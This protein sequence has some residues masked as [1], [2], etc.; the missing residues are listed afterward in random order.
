MRPFALICALI[1]LLFSLPVQADPA[2]DNFAR[3]VE[4]TE[5]LR[6]VRALQNSYANYAQFGLWTEVG[7]LFAAEG[8]FLFD[9]Q[10]KDGQTAKGP[11]AVATFLRTRYGGGRDGQV[12][13]GLSAMMIDSPVINLAADGESAKARWQAI[14]FHGHDGKARIEGGVFVNDYM[15][16]G[17][18]WKIAT[19]H[20]YPQYDGAYEDGWVNW[21]GGDLPVPP[22]HFDQDNAGIAIPPPTGVAAP[23]KAPLAALQARTDRLNEEDRIRNLQSM[24]GFY[25]DRKMWDDVADLFAEDAAVEVGGQGVWRGKAGVRRWLAGIGAAELSHGQL[26]D[27]VQFNV[28]VTIAPGGNE[29]FA[30]GLELGMLGEADQE[31]GWWEIA[32]F[33]NRFVRENGVWKIR[34]MRRFPQMKTDIFLGWGESRITDPV[35]GGANAPD[36]PVPQGDVTGPRTAVPAF[37]GVHPVTGKAVVPRGSSKTV[38]ALPLTGAIAARKAAPV[39]LDEAKRRLARSAAYDG[40]VNVSSAYGFLL[41]DGNPAGFGGLIA[42]KGFKV[43]PFAG[44]YIGRDRVL[45]ARTSGKVPEKRPGISYH[46]LVQPVFLISDDGRSVTGHVRLFQPRTGKTVGEAGAFFGASFWGG[47]YYNEYVLEKG[48]WRLWNLSLDE[49]F[50]K[51]VAWKDGLWAK[52]KDPPPPD[53]NVPARV[54]SG[55][56]FPP[57]IPLKS[58]GKRAE[59]YWGGTGDTWDWPMI[60]PMWFEYTNPVSGRVPPLYHPD[61]IPCAVR[62]ELRLDRN[63]YQQPPDA[64]AANKSP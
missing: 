10:I 38:A 36:G 39:T 21:G 42:E 55:G 54:Y 19:A 47:I 34:E 27:R 22:Y 9:G 8:Q 56:N 1:G 32:T 40:S 30:R 59:H 60:L 12:A 57:D 18:V 23:A 50:I 28:I 37:L 24:Y 63:G 14:I 44:Y 33:H 4:R 20:Y 49:P 13:G 62:P 52:A 46:W 64:P 2:L 41:D 61:C 26:N 48:V 45:A 6:A 16:Q 53:P 7:A 31:K 58:L 43:T 51:P 3:D 11:A 29:A 5:S 17:G 35:P 25:A 15:R